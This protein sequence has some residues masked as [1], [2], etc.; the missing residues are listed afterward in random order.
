MRSSKQSDSSS[1]TSG[2]YIP[3][4]MACTV[5]RKIPL[6]RLKNNRGVMQPSGRKR[7]TVCIFAAG[8]YVIG[9]SRLSSREMTTN[10]HTWVTGRLYVTYVAFRRFCETICGATNCIT[11]SLSY[12][13]GQ[14]A[15]RDLPPRQSAESTTE[16]IS[17][18]SLGHAN[19]GIAPLHTRQ[20]AL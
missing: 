3:Q 8:L 9:A 18:L 5:Y 15:P 14:V 20:R 7:L 1:T 13:H 6:N 16:C 12:V 10:G 4:R 11:P 2:T 19:S 17:M